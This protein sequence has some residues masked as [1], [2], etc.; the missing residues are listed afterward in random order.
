MHTYLDGDYAEAVRN[1]VFMFIVI[2]FLAFRS[3]Y[4]VYYQ[5]KENSRS[6]SNLST[7]SDDEIFKENESDFKT[8]T[9]INLLA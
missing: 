7:A 3:C 9:K 4:S 8:S 1:I 5:T 2:A 6:K